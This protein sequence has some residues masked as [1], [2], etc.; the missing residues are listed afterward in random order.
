MKKYTI[1]YVKLTNQNSNIMPTFFCQ[2]C[3]WNTNT[4][5]SGVD[6]GG[7]DEF[8]KHLINSHIQN[9]HDNS[10]ISD[11]ETISKVCKY[12]NKLRLRQIYG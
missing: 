7:I 12:I 9:E 5:T 10:L 1:K 4:R 2:F 8:I 3:E 11:R 6:T